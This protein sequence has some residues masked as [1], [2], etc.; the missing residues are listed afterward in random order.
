MRIMMIAGV[1]LVFGGCASKWVAPA[2]PHNDLAAK[3]CVGITD[4]AKWQRCVYDFSESIDVAVQRCDQAFVDVPT[5]DRCIE[6]LNAEIAARTARQAQQAVDADVATR[7]AQQ[8]SQ[9]SS[10]NA[11]TLLMLLGAGLS[12]FAQARGYGQPI[13]PPL[14]TTCTTNGGITNCLSY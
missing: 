5:W 10:D 9:S 11:A 4:F 6:T 13:H 2:N 7:Q 8:Q 12:G 1:A 3:A 14:G